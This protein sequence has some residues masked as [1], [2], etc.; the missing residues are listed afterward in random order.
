MLQN[1]VGKGEYTTYKQTVG[2]QI[3]QTKDDL[4]LTAQNLQT[5]V[6]SSTGEIRQFVNG[7]QTYM[8]YSTNGLELG[9]VGSA[10]KTKISNEKISF[11]QDGEEIAYISNRKLYITE[12]QITQRLL[13]GVGDTELFA[14]VTTETGYG[15]KWIG[16]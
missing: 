2:T 9:A 13:F 5:Y 6:D 12:A 11:L 10:F 7:V 3:Q 4:T 15:L 16:S 1:Y 14:W 8:R